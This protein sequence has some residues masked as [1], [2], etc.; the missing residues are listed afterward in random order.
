[1]TFLYIYLGLYILLALLG[2][3]DDIQSGETLSYV[4]LIS[5]SSVLCIL[6]ILGYMH[7]LN[8]QAYIFP[9]LVFALGM[10]SLSARKDFRALLE[11]DS[12]SRNQAVLAISFAILINF[13]AYICGVLI[14][15]TS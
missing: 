2:L 1:M 6:F 14:W 10:E 11:E 4:L 9:M 13:P 7:D 15:S 3:Y 8:I 5:A 12:L